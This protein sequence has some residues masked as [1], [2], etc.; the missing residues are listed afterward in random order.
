M[1][2]LSAI[3]VVFWRSF[4]LFTASKR[5]IVLLVFSILLCAFGTV[6][7]SLKAGEQSSLPVGI[8]DYDNTKA[9]KELINKMEDN[10]VIL[11]NTGSKARLFNKMEKRE[12]IAV[13]EIKSGFEERIKK[14]DMEG[15][16]SVTYPKGE[17]K[18]FLLSDIIAGDLM[19]GLIGGKTNEYYKEIYETEDDEYLKYLETRKD[20][21]MFQY[22]FSI[23]YEDSG[24]A[25]KEDKGFES[26]GNNEKVGENLSLIYY[27]FMNVFVAAVILMLLLEVVRSLVVPDK[28]GI[29]IRESTVSKPPFGEFLGVFVFS[30]LFFAVILLVLGIFFMLSFVKNGH[31]YINSYIIKMFFRDLLALIVFFVLFYVGRRK[32]LSDCIYELLGMF[33]I[34]IYGTALALSNVPHTMFLGG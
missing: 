19:D 32:I 4:K 10:P 22:K 8:V 16:F 27:E 18:C 29:G 13:Y 30:L 3:K 5:N 34:F 11:V 31:F 12:I 9:S 7:L 21:P 1:K 6:M 28:S 25:D 17:E 24:Y 26:A 20:D 14:G 23:S 2:F 15:L 33:L